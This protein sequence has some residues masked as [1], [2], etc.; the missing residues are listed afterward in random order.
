[1]SRLYVENVSKE[2]NLDELKSLFAKYGE[3]KSFGIKKDSGYIVIF[4][5]ILL[6]YNRNIQ[7]QMRLLWLSKN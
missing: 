5:F 6:I 7:V 4:L 1:M 2:A 3:L